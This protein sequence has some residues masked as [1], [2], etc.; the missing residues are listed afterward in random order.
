MLRSSNVSNGNIVLEDNVYV[1]SSV[2]LSEN[3]RAG[4][5]IVVVRNGSRALIGKHAQVK[6]S[7]PSTVI[8]AFM[9]GVRSRCP[10]FINV[11]LST[12]AFDDEVAK[13]MGATIN[14]ITLGM[15]GAMSFDFPDMAEQSC[16]GA[17]FAKLDSLIALHQRERVEACL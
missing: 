1:K 15:F 17:L 3:V 8:G 2:A 7:M 9:T 11:L 16:I 14:Q 4:D 6:R 12:R 5:V 13:N 10:Q